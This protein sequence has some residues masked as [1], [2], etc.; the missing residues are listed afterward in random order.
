VERWLWLGSWA[1][2]DTLVEAE[3]RGIGARNCCRSATA[4]SSLFVRTSSCYRASASFEPIYILYV[5]GQTRQPLTVSR[6]KFCPGS[7]SE[8]SS[9]PKPQERRC[10]VS[11]PTRADPS[12]LTGSVT[13][14]DTSWR[15]L[16]CSSVELQYIGDSCRISTFLAAKF[17]PPKVLLDE[18]RWQHLGGRSD[19]SSGLLCSVWLVFYAEPQ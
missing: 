13:I 10:E 16:V 11:R 8:V 5:F 15:H 9:T 17:L 18:P 4:S 1:G 14:F 19:P 6:A 7:R 12:R 2:A 3:G